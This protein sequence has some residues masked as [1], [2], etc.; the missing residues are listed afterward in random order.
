MRKWLALTAL[1]VGCVSQT[2][3]TDPTID[4]PPADTTPPAIV[5]NPADFVITP[6]GYYHKD[7]VF[8]VGD[9]ATIVS[10]ERVT[11][12]DGT[13]RDLPGCTHEHYASLAD[14]SEG[15]PK[16]DND[17]DPTINGWVMNGNKFAGTWYKEISGTWAVPTAPSHWANQT[18]FFFPGL[19]PATGSTIVQPVLQYGPSA[20]GGGKFWGIASWNCNK[21]CPHT[22]VK[23]VGVGDV[24]DGVAKGTHCTA[25][26]ACTWTITAH[27]RHNGATTTLTR[28]VGEKMIWAAVALEAYNI[29]RCDEY[30]TAGAFAMNV[31]V[32]RPDGTKS[33]TPWTADAPSHVPHC[34]DRVVG[35]GAGR[36]TMFWNQ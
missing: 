18:V 1:T 19:E 22:G 25:G 12:A 3:S 34:G 30:S 29:T 31:S 5:E 33:P 11:L 17:I 36:V 13:A 7:C 9:D 20:A 8:D 23:R 6:A 26:G 15:R 35:Q 14:I 24:I 21:S 32:T 10:D 2:D 16:L 28:A 4:D 27:D